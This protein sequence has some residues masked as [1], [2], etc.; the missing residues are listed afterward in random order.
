MRKL[1]PVET[2][3]RLANPSVLPKVRV[4][5]LPILF[6]YLS[7]YHSFPLTQ[8][9]AQML[10]RRFAVHRARARPQEK[11]WKVNVSR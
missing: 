6:Q 4:C 10:Q 7:L 8:N 5:S 2:Q 11:A 3:M 1:R 9:M